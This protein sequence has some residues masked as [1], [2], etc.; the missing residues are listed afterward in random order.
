[1]TTAWCR[2][3]TGAQVNVTDVRFNALMAKAATRLNLAAHFVGPAHA[4]TMVHV[5]AD[6]EGHLGT[7]GRYAYGC[8]CCA[9][10]PLI[11]DPWVVAMLSGW[12]P[13]STCVTRRAC[14][15]RC[16]PIVLCVDR[17]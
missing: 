11:P 14:S 1:M 7:D 9:W 4:Q 13:G 12:R 8:A 17:T 6:L 10:V 2:D 3:W 5:A 15:P 16:R